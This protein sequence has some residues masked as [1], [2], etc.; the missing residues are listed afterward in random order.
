L[1]VGLPAPEERRS[2]VT[3]LLSKSTFPACSRLLPHPHLAALSS[4]MFYLN[5][6]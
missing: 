4:Q 6:F 1:I 5:A 2:V 3:A